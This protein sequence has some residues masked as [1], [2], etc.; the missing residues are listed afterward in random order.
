MAHTCCQVPGSGVRPIKGVNTT[1]NVTTG[2]G[3]FASMASMATKAT[4]QLKSL[5]LAAA[6]AEKVSFLWSTGYPN[7]LR[8]NT[9]GQG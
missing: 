6:A 8:T 7:I 9:L 2:G 5:R 4:N 1:T 3:I